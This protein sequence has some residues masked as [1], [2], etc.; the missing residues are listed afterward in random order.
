M[1]ATEPTIEDALPGRESDHLPPIMAA[2][3]RR[4]ATGPVKIEYPCDEADFD[5]LVAADL[6]YRSG[7]QWG[8]TSNGREALGMSPARRV[9][10]NQ[11]RRGRFD[12]GTTRIPATRA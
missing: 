7:D 3:I 9:P 4:M 2:A 11:I 1:F 8:I 10:S 5:A 12:L 6:A